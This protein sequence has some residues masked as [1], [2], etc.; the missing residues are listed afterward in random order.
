MQLALLTQCN[1]IIPDPN[2]VLYSHE[3]KSYIN[4]LMSQAKD[5][6]N[7]NYKAS[8]TLSLHLFFLHFVS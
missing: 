7:Q 5:F 4:E 6:T 2:T 3:I 1:N 8:E